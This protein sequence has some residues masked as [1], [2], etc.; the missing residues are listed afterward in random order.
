MAAWDE[1]K[2]LMLKPEEIVA[3]SEMLVLSVL[4]RQHRPWY[5]GY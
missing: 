1:V 4:L 3:I 2:A 5:R